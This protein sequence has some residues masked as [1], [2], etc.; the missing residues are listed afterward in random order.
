MGDIQGQPRGATW[1]CGW[2]G[3]RETLKVCNFQ[4][5]LFLL[6]S[7]KSSTGTGRDG[8]T[9]LLEKMVREGRAEQKDKNHQGVKQRPGV[10]N[11]GV[12]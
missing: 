1:P 3:W 7:R 11:P 5:I 2:S 9:L 10:Q 4:N 8:E 6:Q 12:A